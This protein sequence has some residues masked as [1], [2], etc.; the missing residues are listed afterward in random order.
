MCHILL[1]LPLVALPLLWLLPPR[2]GVPLYGL[3]SAS[4]VVIYW[5]AIKAMRQPLLN[6]LDG[7]LG[8]RGTVAQ[9][10]GD[11]ILVQIHGEIWPAIMPSAT[12]STGDG[13]EIIGF[14]C[15]ILTIRQLEH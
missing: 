8:E 6:G 1:A 12:A 9:V 4:A 7:M 14:Q 10:D 13:I 15:T 5:Y 3:A 2:I 11:S